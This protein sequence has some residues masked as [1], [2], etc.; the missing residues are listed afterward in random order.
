MVTLLFML[1]HGVVVQV[2]V[3]NEHC[4]PVYS[5]K[6]TSKRTAIKA[7]LDSLISECCINTGNILLLG[8]NAGLVSSIRGMTVQHFE[9]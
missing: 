6:F 9:V 4:G 1:F 2:L 7:I 5:K 3:N 8:D